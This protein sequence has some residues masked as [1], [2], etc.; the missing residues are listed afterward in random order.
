MPVLSNILREFEIEG[1]VYFSDIL[2]PPWDL[3]FDGM[4]TGSFHYVQ[5]GGCRLETEG[6]TQWL[7]P[8]DVAIVP[9]A[10][11]Q[12]L[13]SHQDPAAAK[14]IGD[15]FLLCGYFSFRQD[16]SHPLFEL[17]P[18]VMILR[19]ESISHN[20]WLKTTLDHL[21]NEARQNAPG[22]GHV[23]D[24]L[25]EVLLVL[26][27]RQYMTTKMERAS[28]I[29]ALYDSQI[30]QALRLLHDAPEKPWT[31]ASVAKSVAMSRA[32]FANRFKAL[33]G[34]PMYSYL[35]G[36]RMTVARRLLRETSL[37]VGQ[38]ANQ[39]G[40]SSE[41]AFSRAFRKFTGEAAVAYRR[42]EA[43]PRVQGGASE[44]PGLR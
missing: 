22:A 7:G 40:Y 14:S 18:P 15:S 23:L 20:R 5:R 41:S 3:D 44:E 26:M 43:G 25:T 24:N 34:V 2:S 13:K 29:Q 9:V 36:T 38:I 16:I 12:S 33:V 1:S 4:K 39:V 19:D 27:L 31:L 17:F 21:V 35:T 42:R 28:F 6:E 37:G 10:R 11:H 30:S 32:V 8:G